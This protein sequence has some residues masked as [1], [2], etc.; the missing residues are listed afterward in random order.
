MF[1]L[2]SG[3]FT[4]RSASF[5]CS[6]VSSEKGAPLPGTTVAPSV[7]DAEWSVSFSGPAVWRSSVDMDALRLWHSEYHHPTR[8]PQR[9]TPACG[10]RRFAARQVQPS[11]ALILLL[12]A[13]L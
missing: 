13:R 11:S 8:P 9:E 7:G 3:S 6:S 4:L 10:G 2:R 12:R 5:T 1:R